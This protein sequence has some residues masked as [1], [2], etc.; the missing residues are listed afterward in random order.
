M[1]DDRPDLPEGYALARFGDIDSTNLEAV[2]QAEHGE[3]GP[4]WIWAERQLAGRGRMGRSWIS[5]RGN[6]YATLL[7]PLNAG[8]RASDLSFVTVL[9]V[10]DAAKACLPEKAHAKLKLKWPND[11][12]LGGEKTAGILLEQA[13]SSS[14]AIGC[15]L[16][17]GNVPSSGARRPAT[18]LTLHGADVSAS[19]ALAHLALAMDHW[20]RVWRSSGFAL[21]RQAWLERATGQ[22]QDITVSQGGENLR[23]TFKTLDDVGALILELPDGREQKIFAA[24]IELNS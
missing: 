2:R 7:L 16:N 3:S 17:L 10:C 11:L 18:G 21:I 23:G 13:G 24:D 19:A 9:S 6:L 8:E 15:G 4:I 20:L 1:S 14:V 12:L 22:G 5:E